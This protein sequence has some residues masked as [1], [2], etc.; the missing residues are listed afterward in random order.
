MSPRPRKSKWAAGVRYTADDSTPCKGEADAGTIRW[1]GKDFEGCN[2][3]KWMS[4]TSENTA[5]VP[6]VTSATG[7]VWMDRNLGASRVAL[8]PYDEESFGDFYQWGRPK[9]GHEKSDS[10]TTQTLSKG[11]VPGHDEFI[12]RTTSPWTWRGC[13]TAS[14]WQGIKGGVNNPCPSGFRLPTTAEFKKEL[15]YYGHDDS[16][17]LFYSPLKLPLT[18][19]RHTDGAIHSSKV[20]Y[21]T[22]YLTQTAYSYSYSSSGSPSDVSC[23]IQIML[24]RLN[25]QNGNIYLEN[26]N[27]TSAGRPVR[28]IQ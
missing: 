7:Q 19:Y 26:D 23:V 15:E 18:G 11:I 25:V 12:T 21:T 9:D 6:I 3:T 16:T 1:T 4:L 14:P 17:D 22:S 10:A 20:G 13:P 27:I 8:A 24:L 28:C 2:G 5:S